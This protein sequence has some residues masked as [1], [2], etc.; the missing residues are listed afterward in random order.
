M[1]KKV[2]FVKVPPL[3]GDLPPEEVARALDEIGEKARLRY[4][5]T[6][7]ELL[8]LLA[9]NDPIAL[10]AFMGLRF[11]AVQALDE[12]DEQRP[13]AAQQHHLELL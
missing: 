1:G 12:S 11:F 5:Q 2:E 7:K 10:L 3:L 9:K 13:P 4:E 6:S 8:D